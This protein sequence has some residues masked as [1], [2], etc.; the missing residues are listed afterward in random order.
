MLKRI[1]KQDKAPKLVLVCF[2][3]GEQKGKINAGRLS[4]QEAFG[5]RC[6]DLLRRKHMWCGEKVPR[7]LH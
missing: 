7:D 1:R 5:W 4:F 3:S 2:F 6:V